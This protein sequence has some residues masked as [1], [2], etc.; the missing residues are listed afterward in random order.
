VRHSTVPLA[1]CAAAFLAACSGHSGSPNSMLPSARVSFLRPAYGS[2]PIDH[3]VLVVQENRTFNNFF[4]TFPGATGT[5]TGQKNVNGKTESIPLT[6]IGLESQHNLNHSYAGYLAAYDGGKMDGFNLVHYPSG[7]KTE[8]SAPYVYVNPEEIAP[9]WAMAQ[10]Y[11]LANAMFT[12]QGSASFPAHQDLIRGGTE[13]AANESLI[14]NPPYGNAWGCDSA[15]GTKTTLITTKLKVKRGAGPFPCTSD[16]PGSGDNYLTLRD[17]LDAKSVSWKFYT[18]AVGDS[19][20]IWDAFD[21]IAPV[22]YGSEW[23][24]NIV[25]PETTIFDDIANGTLANMSWVIPDG[26]NSD[27]PNQG[28]DTGPS[29]VASIVNAV[30]ESQYWNTCAIVVVWDDW[31]GFYDP[32]KP[33]PH[34][35]QG[36]P[37]FRVPMI[38]VSPY[39][40]ETSASQPGYISNTIYEFGSIIQFVE[41][42]FNLG[43]LGTTDGTTN[44][45]LDMFD[46]DQYPRSFTPIGSKYSRSYFLHRKPSNIPVDNE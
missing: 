18:P 3:I 23:G 13:I 16:F 12:T 19:G 35:N 44:S 28:Y 45:M 39:S 38:V 15:P 9:Y 14:D 30:G 22:R 24:T 6:E 31:G 25:S 20:A 36:G 11:G 34:D 46:F 8:N 7:R 10:Q 21:V 32:V 27:H 1:L 37:G 17:L 41:D 42:T 4:A 43:R 2:S 40:R 5:T 26:A 33:P 29:W